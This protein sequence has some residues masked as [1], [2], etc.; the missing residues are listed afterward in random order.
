MPKRVLIYCM[1]WPGYAGHYLARALRR[2]GHDVVT[3]GAP[4]ACD[5]HYI[6]LP[7]RYLW[8]PDIAVEPAGELKVSRALEILGAFR[9]GWQPNLILNTESVGE[10]IAGKTPVCPIVYYAIDNH[11]HP[12][13]YEPGRVT[14]IRRFAHWFVAHSVGFFTPSDPGVHWLPCGYDPYIHRYLV[15]IEDRPYSIGMIGA[16]YADRKTLIQTLAGEFDVLTGIGP[17]FADYTALY[18][19]CKIS[20][21]DPLHED[22]AMR[23]FETAAMGCVLLAR[24]TPDFDGLGLVADTHYLAYQHPHDALLQARSVLSDPAR[25]QALSDN[26]RQWVT[27]HSWD[28]RARELLRVVFGEDTPASPTPDRVNIDGMRALW[29]KEHDPYLVLVGGKHG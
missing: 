16:P 12:Y 13:C 1:H 14:M 7:A 11:I 6:P 26:V 21:C 15:P 23:V 4:K 22:V 5:W 2:L 27:G 10:Y 25:L 9:P 28:D 3:M 20:L 18:N 17:M 24:P 29:A 19:Q 8:Q